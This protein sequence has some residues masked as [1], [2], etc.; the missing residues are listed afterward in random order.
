M[1]ERR[2]ARLTG[3]GANRT[4]YNVGMTSGDRGDS[5]NREC[6]QLWR[7]VC[8]ARMAKGKRSVALFEVIQSSK[9]AQR[10]SMMRTPSWW[11]K[12]RGADGSQQKPA[13]DSTSDLSSSAPAPR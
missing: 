12:R 3:A 6:R 2:A 1:S 8:E 4:F 7:P 13:L 11:F 10:E 5:E 9:S